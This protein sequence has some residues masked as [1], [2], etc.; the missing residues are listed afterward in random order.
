MADKKTD[1]T[2]EITAA[3]GKAKAT[4]EPTYTLEALRKH[5]LE[6]FGVSAATFAGATAGIEEREYTVNEVKS[7]IKVWCGKVVK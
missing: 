1:A 2:V 6:L 3:Q 5:C 4:S 7:I